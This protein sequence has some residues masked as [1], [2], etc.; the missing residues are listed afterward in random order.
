MIRWYPKLLFITAFGEVYGKLSSE[1]K[2]L[3]CTNFNVIQ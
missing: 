1:I 3:F 2:L